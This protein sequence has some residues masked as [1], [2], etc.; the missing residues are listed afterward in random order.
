MSKNFNITSALQ[1]AYKLLETDNIGVLGKRKSNRSK[2][3]ITEAKWVNIE[4]YLPDKA[5]VESLELQEEL[6]DM[7]EGDKVDDCPQWRKDR[8]NER[9]NTYR[10]L[11]NLDE[12]AEITEEHINKHNRELKALCLRKGGTPEEVKK[13]LL[14]GYYE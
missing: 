1:E 11:C 13:Q 2:K 14:K 12:S 6:E 9:I 8:V 3:I 5:Y 4:D 7:V 10:E